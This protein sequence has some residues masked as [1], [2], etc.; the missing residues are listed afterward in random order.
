MTTRR[1]LREGCAGQ[2]ENKDKE[3][4]RNKDK[5]LP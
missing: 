4:E 2:G 3:K 1:K 5:A